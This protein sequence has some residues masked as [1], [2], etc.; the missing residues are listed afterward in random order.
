MLELEDDEDVSAAGGGAATVAFNSS[1]VD[2]VN[3][4]VYT[5]TFASI[6]AG[7]VVVSVTGG[8][9]GTFTVSGITVGGAA[10]TEVIS[11]AD[12][13]AVAGIWQLNDYAGGSSVDVVVTWTGTKGRCGVGVT[14]LG[15]AAAAASATATSVANPSV[16]VGGIDVPANGA[17]VAVVFTNGST[18]RTHTWAELDEDFDEVIETTVGSHSGASK[19]FAAEQTALAIGATQSGTSTDE[20]F[21]AASWGPV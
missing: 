7:K 14:V 19:A 11:V 20:A 3:R 17:A 18:D 10:T 12:N 1:Q 4:T 8:G 2:A 15:N 16:P 6:A 13:E 21:V 5:R 9:G